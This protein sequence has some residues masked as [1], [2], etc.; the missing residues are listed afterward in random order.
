MTRIPAA[1][2]DTARRA[3]VG[4]RDPNAPHANPGLH[5]DPQSS[6]A[7]RVVDQVVECLSE[8]IGVGHHD[9]RARPPVKDERTTRGRC[10]PAP[11][12]HGGLNQGPAGDRTGREPPRTSVD[13]PVE[14]SERRQRDPNRV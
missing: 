2:W 13:L 7:E 6:M 10:R 4:D 8:T 5:T 1:P 14:V 3:R 12:L 9:R 11:A